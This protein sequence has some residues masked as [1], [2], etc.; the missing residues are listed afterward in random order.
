MTPSETL[1]AALTRVDRDL[2]GSLDRLLAFL[3]IQS[4][5]TDPAYKPHCRTAA[6]HV[7][8]LSLHCARR[9]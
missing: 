9:V 1:P 2:E 7:A 8:P 6:E 3:R 4:I 5:S